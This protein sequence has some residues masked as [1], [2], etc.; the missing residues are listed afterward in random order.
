M[1]RT[2]NRHGSEYWY[3]SCA[4]RQRHH[5]DIAFQPLD[6]V[7]AQV[8]ER[9][10]LLILPEGFA[11]RVREVLQGTVDHE[12]RSAKLIAAQVEAKLRELDSQEENLLDLAAECEVP[13]ERIR[14]R[15]AKIAEER[16]RLR[17]EGRTSALRR[18]RIAW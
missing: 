2:K 8:F 1:H 12:V 11:M 14:A 5:C 9:F 17:E 18:E 3:N 10:A 13:K 7:E 15:V 16:T 4:G 6:V